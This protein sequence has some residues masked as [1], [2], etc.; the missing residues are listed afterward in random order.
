MRRLLR[1][2]RD[3]AA[4]YARELIAGL[5]I[6]SAL[7]TIVVTVSDEDHD[8]R[9]DRVTVTVKAEAPAGDLQAAPTGS[10]P[11][12]AASVLRDE[13]P[14]SVPAPVLASAEA[15]EHAA[16][17][18]LPAVTAPLPVGG[19]QSYTCEQDFSGHVYNDRRPGEKVMSVKLHYTVS[20]NI[21]GWGD[22]YG[23]R[24]YFHRTRRGSSHLIV[25]FEAHCL[26]MVPWEKNAWTQGA[27]NSTSE[28]IEIIAT[29]LETREQWLNAPLIKRGTLADIV[30][31]RLRARGL[32]ATRVDPDGCEDKLGVTDHDAL[33]CG[34]N[35]TDVAPSFPWDVFMRQLHDGPTAVTAVDRHT[36]RKLNW[37]R[38]H[39][40]PHGLPERRAIR[41]RH[42]LT[43]RDVR[44]TRRGPVRT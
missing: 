31:D 24:D 42:T 38:A 43:S 33:E 26:Q 10:A 11:A 14:P 27:F 30:R 37:W 16:A 6:I 39:G 34:N 22:V 7:V 20:A 28:S 19:A 36:C 40:R 2:L 32:P 13:T 8:G 23:V 25:D 3:A 41:R 44:C 17:V 18:E 9:P 29:G 5:L 35:H 21:L 1:A 15:R 12:P 4:P